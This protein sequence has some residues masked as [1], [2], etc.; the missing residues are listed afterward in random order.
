MS[1]SLL[2]P[3]ALVSSL[4]LLTPGEVSAGPPLF[5]FHCPNGATGEL[6]ANELAEAIRVCISTGEQPVVRPIRE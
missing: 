3:L 1:R 6:R 4:L 5:F 2:F